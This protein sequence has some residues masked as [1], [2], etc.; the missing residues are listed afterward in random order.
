M[1]NTSEK[2]TGSEPNHRISGNPITFIKNVCIVI[3]A[4][5]TVTW[6]LPQCSKKQT[7]QITLVY[8]NKVN[9]EP[10]ILATDKGFCRD[11]G[12]DVEVLAVVGGIVA[13]EAIATGSADIAAMGDAP[14]IIVASKNPNIRIV[15]RYGC[16]E[17]IHR[18]VTQK[19]ITAPKQLEGKKVGIQLGSSTH[20]AFLL[21]TEKNGLDIE[22]VDIVSLNPL[23][24]PDAMFTDQID[25]IAGSEPWPTNVK[26]RCGD[27]VRELSSSEGLGN[28]FP[29]VLVATEKLLLNNPKS[30]EKI[31]RAVKKATNYINENI[32][33]SARLISNYTGLPV[34]TQKICMSRLFWNVAFDSTDYSSM[35]ITSAFLKDFGKIEQIPDFARIIDASF[36]EEIHE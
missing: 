12:L 23:D 31:L 20:G 1:N 30:V 24:M 16:G 2:K 21:W 19:S 15:A 14:A 6:I 13:A 17:G 26:N 36:L 4:I 28:T 34:E 11:E 32:D 10:L 9:Y 25:A 18:I 22:N 33:D 8:S 35:A 3:I 5:I 29:H 27:K 7:D